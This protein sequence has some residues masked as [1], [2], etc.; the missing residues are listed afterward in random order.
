MAMSQDEENFG[1]I[2]RISTD[3]W[4]KQVYDRKK[5]YSGVMRQWKRGNV[6]LLAKKTDAGDSFIGYGVIDKVEMLWELSP[7]DEAYCKEHGWKCAISFQPLIRFEKPYP[8]RE[9]ILADDPRKGRL[10]HGAR[11]TE[12]QVDAILE[13]AEDQQS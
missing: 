10:L 13:A 6:I 1:Y 9:S 2:L 3:E 12:D 4:L 11:L 7:E 5:Y 8:I